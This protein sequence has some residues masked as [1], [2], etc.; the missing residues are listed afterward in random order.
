MADDR[1]L[2]CRHCGARDRIQVN[3][4]MEAEVGDGAPWVGSR[5]NEVDY[6]SCGACGRVECLRSDLC[7]IGY[8]GITDDEKEAQRDDY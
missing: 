4:L 3:A 5:V 1:Y 8:P 2:E 6:W 7:F